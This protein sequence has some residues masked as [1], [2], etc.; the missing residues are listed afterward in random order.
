MAIAAWWLM[1][2]ASAPL[3]VDDNAAQMTGGR[4]TAWP[5]HEEVTFLRSSDGLFRVAATV[6]GKTISMIVDTGAT[7]SIIGEKTATRLGI[8]LPTDKSGKSMQTLAGTVPF[9]EAKVARL[10]VGGMVLEQLEVAVM[11]TSG[12]VSVLG[13]DAISRLGVVTLS[14]DRLTIR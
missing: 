10:N 2:G 7:T 13:Q 9:G 4:A 3:S 6:D 1:S 5:G 14:G 8:A 11:P 12:D